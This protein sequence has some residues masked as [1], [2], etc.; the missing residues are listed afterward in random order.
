M[1]PLGISSEAL[2]LL[3][4]RLVL[5]RSI[6]LL[7]FRRPLNFRYDVGRPTGGTLGTY[8]PQPRQ[9][10]VRQQVWP[11]RPVLKLKLSYALSWINAT[12]YEGEG[13]T[14]CIYTVLYIY[15]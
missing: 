4:A 9:I 7:R 2:C 8:D 14:Y 13:G 5:S 11:F 15:S 1:S 6:S 12:V 10:L 3:K